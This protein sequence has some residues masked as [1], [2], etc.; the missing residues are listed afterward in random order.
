MRWDEVTMEDAGSTETCPRGGQID[1]GSLRIGV[2]RADIV[3]GVPYAEVMA[4][5][6]GDTEVCILQ[7][8]VPM[9]FP[10]GAL[11]LTTVELGSVEPEA[12]FRFI[13]S[14]LP[15]V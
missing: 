1:W 8:G 3:E 11:I 15:I 7:G 4:F 2:M 9:D 12:T 10:S 13:P 5:Y 14:I 6:P